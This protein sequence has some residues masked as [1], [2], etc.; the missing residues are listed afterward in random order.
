MAAGTQVVWDVDLLGE[1]VVR[2]YRADNPEQPT[3]YGRGE[4]AEAE[5]ALARW[6]MRV[7]RLFA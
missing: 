4:M 5:P 2:L 1:G 7:D 3:V 6:E